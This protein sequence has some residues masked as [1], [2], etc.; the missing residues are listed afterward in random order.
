MLVH[1][2]RWDNW[3]V[4]ACH[5]EHAARDLAGKTDTPRL[6]GV[7]VARRT[8]DRW[9]IGELDS[10]P[11]RDHQVVLEHLLGFPCVELF[12]PPPGASGLARDACTDR[13]GDELTAPGLRLASQYDVAMLALDKRHGD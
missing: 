2:R 11:Q 1:E 6:L 3:C 7:S 12:G 9:M 5:L 8:F 13:C 4:F 10:L